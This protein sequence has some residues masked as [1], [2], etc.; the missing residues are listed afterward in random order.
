MKDIA[1][2][3]AEC[4]T[5]TSRQTLPQII[6]KAIVLLE[7][8]VHWCGRH[9]AC[10]RVEMHTT[11]GIGY[12]LETPCRINDPSATCVNIEGAVARACND[13]GIAPP[14]LMRAL[15][16]WT[17]DYLNSLG[18]TGY[19]TEQGAWNEHGVGWFGEHYVYEEAMN[20]LRYILER[21][22]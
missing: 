17:L 6:H 9:V 21:V 14:A 13:R 10:R 7:D 19:G 15:D 20:L 5:L 2:F 3:L 16:Q 8:P 1:P 12:V 18:V 22:S 4:D 11:D